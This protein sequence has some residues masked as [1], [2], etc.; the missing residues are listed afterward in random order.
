MSITAFTIFALV[1]FTGSDATQTTF[2]Q[3]GAAGSG[4]LRMRKNTSNQ[5]DI[6]PGVGTI[7]SSTSTF[8][9][10]SGWVFI[11][12]SKA[13]GTVTAVFNFYTFSNNTWTTENSSGTVANSGTPTGN[14]FL[15]ALGGASQFHAGDIALAGLINANLG[16]QA[17]QAMLN[18]IGPMYQGGTPLALWILDQQAVSQK[19]LD[20]TGGHADESSIAGTTVTTNSLWTPGMG[21]MYS[22]HL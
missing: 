8:T 4:S 16:N 13:A 3:F 14:C 1:N 12:C 18:G 6:I 9:S 7:R 2:I 20:I 10:S 17:V 19:V 11:V 15:G 21:A 22:K 5:I